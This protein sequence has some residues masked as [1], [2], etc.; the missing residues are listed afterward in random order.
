MTLMDR[1]AGMHSTQN[2]VIQLDVIVVPLVDVL[3]SH[4][5]MHGPRCRV[6]MVEIRVI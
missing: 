1:R 6:R 5:E 2:D 4:I 3:P